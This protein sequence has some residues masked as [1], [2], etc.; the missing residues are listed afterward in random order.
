MTHHFLASPGGVGRMRMGDESATSYSSS[1][2][3]ADGHSARR[4]Q[5]C[6]LEAGQHR[7]RKVGSG[8]DT[9]WSCKS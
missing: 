2:S 3:A 6:A 1:P 9:T 4:D 5:V 8:S 7:L